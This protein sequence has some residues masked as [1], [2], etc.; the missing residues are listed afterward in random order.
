MTFEN[1]ILG[2]AGTYI[3]L[4]VGC[5]VR[6]LGYKAGLDKAYEVLRD[7]IIAIEASAAAAI[8]EAYKLGQNTAIKAAAQVAADII[9]DEFD[10]EREN[11]YDDGWMDG[12]GAERL[13]RKIRKE[14]K[15]EG[16]RKSK[17]LSGK[18]ALAQ[19]S[20]I[21]NAEPIGHVLGLAARPSSP[22]PDDFFGGLG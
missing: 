18:K 3:T 21:G 1:V 12:V 15:R 22:R 19:L 8:E 7:G 14:A 16:K 5:I 17:K 10:N 2:V 13:A 4:G 9:E 20:Y 11:A 6:S